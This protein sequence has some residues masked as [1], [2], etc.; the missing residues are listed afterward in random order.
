[1]G[2]TNEARKSAYVGAAPLL[3]ALC[4]SQ[5]VAAL[6]H[7]RSATVQFRTVG[8]IIKFF[9]IFPIC[10]PVHSHDMLFTMVWFFLQSEVSD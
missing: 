3:A 7:F 10:R 2:V 5:R 8:G 9:P 4:L 6:V 1:M